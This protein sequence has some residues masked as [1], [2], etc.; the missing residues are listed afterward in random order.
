METKNIL[1]G[2]VSIIAISCTNQ[3]ESKV[4]EKSAVKELEKVNQTDNDFPIPSTVSDEA[5]VVLKLFT[6]ENRDVKLPK[7]DDT[8]GW[9]KVWQENEKA[10]QE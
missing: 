7:S 3:P 6:K 8:E 9:K 2:I 5:L 1:F 4:E 10:Q